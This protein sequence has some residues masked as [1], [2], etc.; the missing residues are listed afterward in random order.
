MVWGLLKPKVVSGKVTTIIVCCFYSPPRSRK[1]SVL[2]DHITVTLQSLLNI[3]TNAGVIISGDRNNIDI[4]TLLSID[5]S[6]H[7]LVRMP[8]RGLN[9]LDV[10]VT[11][12]DRY[13]NEPVIIPAILPDRPGHGVPSDHCGVFATPNT[14]QNHPAEKTKVKKK[15][16]P[17]PESLIQT[18]EDKLA[19]HDF[20][21]LSE[22]PV[23][24]MV[25]AFQTVLQTT[26]C[27]TFP[28][29]EILVSS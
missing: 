18:F 19:S 28:E 12:L 13:F 11:N 7:Q 23:Q 29:R 24:E 1:N 27:E 9:I 6:L 16:R 15:I 22:M 8:T 5:P 25:D 26:L 4:S 20:E 10:I 14:N 17:L 3:H 21:M 2:I